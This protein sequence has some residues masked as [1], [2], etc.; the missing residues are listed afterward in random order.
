MQRAA[1]VLGTLAV[2]VAAADLSAQNRPDLA[3]Q[4]TIVA[5]AGAPPAGAPPGGGARGGRGGGGRGMGAVAGLG[6]QATIV[7]SGNTLTITR[8]SP[9]GEVRTVYNLDGSESRNSAAMGRGGDAV[10]QVS[11]AAWDGDKLV[12]TTTMSMGGNNVETTMSLSLDA[13][14]NLVV[15]SAGMG[16]GGAGGTTTTRYTKGS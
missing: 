10:E 2:L 12:I 4:W 6:Q 14:G 11:R 7:Q 15:E 3:G 16:R 1:A 5:D 13:S 8:T 9:M